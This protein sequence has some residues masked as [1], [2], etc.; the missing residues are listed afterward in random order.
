MAL[1]PEYQAL[2]AQLA[3]AEGPPFSQLSPAEGRAVYRVLR[4]I[5]PD[6]AV[7]D[8]RDLAL[9]GPAGP[10]AARVY[11]PPGKGPFPVLV[12]FH[13]GGWVIGDLDTADSVCR[14]LCRS[15]GCVVVSA[16][17]RLAPEHR[18][19]AAVEDAC[20]VTEW[21]ATHA[22]AL[23]GNGTLAVGGESAGGN[24]AAV[25]SQWARDRGGPKLALQLLL[26]PVTDCDMT[27]PSYGENGVGYLL[28]TDTMHWFWDHYCPDKARR[29]EPL[30]SPLRAASLAHLP[31]AL[32]V[33]A[34]YDP[35]RDEGDAYARA[36]VA[37]G[38]DVEHVRCPGLIHDFFAT[39]PV[40]PSSRRS[41]DAV[42]A[43]LRTRL[44]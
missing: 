2:L 8:V 30:A 28:E 18:Y 7:A 6:I 5:N 38:N 41:F 20:A 32:V 34:E 19:P 43:K 4:P 9:P 21:V 22:D 27:R 39:A 40:F 37:A 12:N 13:G 44:T 3:A 24:L 29:S 33:T 25:V 1:V 36:L 15:V 31:P 35:L 14:D 11:T 42:V 23:H 17:Y 26:Y 10:I 16:D